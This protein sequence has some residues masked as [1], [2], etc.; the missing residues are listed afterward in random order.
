MKWDHEKNEI[1]ALPDAQVSLSLALHTENADTSPERSTDQEV[2]RTTSQPS[3]PE[4]PR[5]G[6]RESSCGHSLE[7]DSGPDPHLLERIA[8]AAGQHGALAAHS[9]QDETRHNAKIPAGTAPGT[10]A[11]DSVIM[12]DVRPPMKTLMNPSS[13]CY[14]N[15]AVTGLVWGA[16]QVNGL[17]EDQWS[18]FP[19]ALSQIAEPFD[20]ESILLWANGHW[21]SL[22]VDWPDPFRLFSPHSSAVEPY[23]FQLLLGIKA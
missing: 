15:A 18:N 14:M 7:C 10:P 2:P 23:V 11:R 19:G 6:L 20:G 13:A 21:T 9:G 17:S 1:Q 22:L 8:R 4:S 12:D 16:T 3:D 5:D